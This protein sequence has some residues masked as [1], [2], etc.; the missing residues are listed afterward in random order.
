MLLIRLDLQFIY[1]LD[2]KG[3][4]CPQCGK[5]YKWR[6]SLRNHRR[7]E[8]G[9]DPQYVCELCPYKTHQKGNY[10]RHLY[11]IHQVIK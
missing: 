9:K 4:E 11:T 8:C 2:M 3:F 7:N 5:T 10:L 6:A 1:V